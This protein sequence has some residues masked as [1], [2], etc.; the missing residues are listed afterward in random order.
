[1]GSD[2]EMYDG[3]LD[4]VVQLCD[5]LT[6]RFGIQRQIPHRYVGPSRRLMIPEQLLGVVGVLGHRD[7]TNR[8]GPGDPGN[9][10][11]NKLG[12]A[13]YEPLDFDQRADLDTWRR[14][15]RGLGI[16]KGVDGVPGPITV[17]F[18]RA[19]GRGKGEAHVP[20]PAGLWVVRPGDSPGPALVT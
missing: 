7:L 5:W 17:R 11:M 16:T 2:A 9:A 4:V 14:R 15:Q 3:Q 13:G 6:R 18:L 12:K 1:M 10:I 20:L 8:R 19:K